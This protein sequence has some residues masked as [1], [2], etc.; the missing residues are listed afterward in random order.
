MRFA[1]AC[2]AE[3]DE[4]PIGTGSHPTPRLDVMHLEI[5]GGSA[6][7]AFPAVS[8]EDLFSKFVTSLPIQSKTR[9]WE[10]R[11]AFLDTCGMICV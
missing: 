3:R 7:L 5:L 1:G 9:V 10:V 4:V 11:L 6:V 2:C 8:L